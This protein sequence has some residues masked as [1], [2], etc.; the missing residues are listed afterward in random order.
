MEEI[1]NVNKTTMTTIES[2]ESLIQLTLDTHRNGLIQF[3]IKTTI[4]NLSFSFAKLI[5]SIYGMNLISEMEEVSGHLEQVVLFAGSCSA[6]IFV[7]LILRLRFMKYGVR[8]SVKRI[9]K[10]FI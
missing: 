6:V 8:K 7:I 10:K 2:T 1:S 3:E 9:Y 4:A 5:T